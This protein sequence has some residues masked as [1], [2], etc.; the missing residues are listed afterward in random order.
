VFLAY[1]IF[2]GI[3]CA[4]LA[5]CELEDTES[6]YCVLMADVLCLLLGFLLL[7]MKLATDYYER[8]Q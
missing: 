1:Y 8:N 6:M 2:S 7:P 3:F 4:T 5:H